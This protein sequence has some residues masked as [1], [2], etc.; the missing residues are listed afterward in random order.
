MLDTLFLEHAH[1]LAMT[2]SNLPPSSIESLDASLP[3]QKLGLRSDDGTMERAFD[4]WMRRRTEQA[5]RDFDALLKENSFVEFWGKVRKLR[6]DGEGANI[7]ENEEDLGITDD[8]NES[9][10]TDIKT[11]A[12]SVTENEMDRVL[13]VCFFIN[14]SCFTPAIGTITRM[15]SVIVPLI[16]HQSNE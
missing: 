10:K 14:K 8:G 11:L 5:R 9:G 7:I 16:I 15:T 1:S 4:S 12:K 3:S 2:F 6:E 13:R